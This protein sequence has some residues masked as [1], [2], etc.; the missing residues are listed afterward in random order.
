M[1]ASPITPV[2]LSGGTGTRLWPLS[3][4][5]VPKQLQPLMGER[6]LLQETALRVAPS[7]R[8]APP[9]VV[10]NNEHR[11]IVAEQLRALGI[12]PREIVLEPV[13]RNT[14]PAVAVAA[15]LLARRDP[16]AA[17]LVLASDHAIGD[18]AAFETAVGHAAD[19]AAADRLVTFGIAPTRPE[20]GYG[21][22]ERGAALDGEAGVH[23][24]AGFAEKPDPDEAARRIAR[25]DLWNSGMFLFRASA[26]LAE[27]ERLAPKLLAA[28]Q[29]ALDAAVRDLDFLRLARE[30]FALA[31]AVAVDVAV[32]EKTERGAVVPAD[33]GWSDVGSWS[34]LWELGAKDAGGN[35][36]LGD[37]VAQG[38]VDCY[39][40]SNGPLVAAI[41]LERHVVVATGDVVL[42]APRDEV[43][44]VR[45]VVAALERQ[46]RPEALRHAEVF[47]PWGWFRTLA[48]GPDF[49]VKRVH[50]DPGGRILLRKHRH[51][52]QHW[53]VADGR[54]RVALGED[55]REL[56]EGEEISIP[57]GT[58]HALDNAGDD[59]LE[60]VEVQTGRHAGRDAFERLAGQ[61]AAD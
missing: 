40:R 23:A 30:P 26:Y 1:P 7:D 24:I 9:L 49:H 21:Y 56:A 57:A 38:T 11:F 41:G 14:A 42:V 50:L 43:Q 2:I 29:N 3:R 55:I 20:T 10:C 12:V 28:C 15:L 58:P 18:V 54:A 19:A 34:A 31:P 35:V 22:I 16:K 4:R 8:Y 51:A 46:E 44:R 37:V 36:V 25:G 61:A 32:M 6:T 53:V 59:A 48:T 45:D 5:D 39:L 52:T 47:R 60:I 27:L 17:M 13:G 33:I